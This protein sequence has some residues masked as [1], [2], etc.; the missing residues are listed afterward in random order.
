MTVREFAAAKVNLFL[1]VLGR[2]PDGY[3]DLDSL[4][5]F[6]DVG[7]EVALTR[8]ETHELTVEGPFADAVPDDE[9]NIALRAVALL[10]EALG[11]E[12]GVHVKITKNLPVAAGLGGGSADAAA[13]LRGLG[14]LWEVGPSMAFP[15]VAQ[16]LGA[17]VPVCMLSRAA[18]LS[19]PGD[20]EAVPV[21][22][23]MPLVLVNCGAAVSTAA[24]FARC[25]TFGAAAPAEIRVEGLAEQRNDLEVAAKS[26]APEI[27]DVITALRATEGC[28]L[29]RM[30][31]SG[32]TCFGLF[33]SMTAAQN[34][35]AALS[36]ARDAWWVKATAVH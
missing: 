21:L 17:D 5:V 24:A 20:A 3:H 22:A 18:R 12:E 9:T 13:T 25:E 15:S 32:A 6:A 1:H 34:A 28:T 11:I 26:I 27:D 19:G 36:E 16:A 8:A 29:A 35:A 4:V 23:P 30:S 14:R 10:S 2:R 33:E 7:D 31:G